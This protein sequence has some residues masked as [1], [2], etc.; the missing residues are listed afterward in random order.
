MAMIAA[1]NDKTIRARWLQHVVL[2]AFQDVV[3]A[4]H[5]RGILVLPRLKPCMHSVRA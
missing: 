4:D 2:N 3:L 1:S 5:V